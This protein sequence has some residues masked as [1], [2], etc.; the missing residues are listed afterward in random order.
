MDYSKD[1]MIRDCEECYGGDFLAMA[2]DYF[3]TEAT[4]IAKTGADII[5]H[6]DLV[7]KFNEQEKDVRGK[8][9]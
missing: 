4:V 8:S 3:A 1:Q 9:P 2:E 6:F 7:T 5:G